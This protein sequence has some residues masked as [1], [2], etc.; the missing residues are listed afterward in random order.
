MRFFIKIFILSTI[1]NHAFAGNATDGAKIAEMCFGCHGKNG[2]PIRY[3]F[4]QLA[5][6][7]KEYMLARLFNFKD[8]EGSSNA[9]RKVAQSLTS[10]QL[11]DLAAYFSEQSSKKFIV[12]KTERIALGKKLYKSSN[13]KFTPCIT[14]HGNDGYSMDNIDMPIL[15]LQH[16][17]YI[18]RRL[19]HFKKSKLG[20]DSSFAD[21]IMSSIAKQLSDHEIRSVA[22]YISSLS[23]V[24]ED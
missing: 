20:V 17:R 15:S 16:P 11:S 23:S 18:T 12:K 24:G 22:D 19:R 9:M 14:C 1:C 10:T 13:G 3:S 7:S 21:V 2:N 6:Q 5:G 4:P 8:G